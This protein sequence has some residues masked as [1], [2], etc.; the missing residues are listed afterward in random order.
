MVSQIAQFWKAEVGKRNGNGESMQQ[1][2]TENV[3]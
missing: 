2:N 3:Q 1:F